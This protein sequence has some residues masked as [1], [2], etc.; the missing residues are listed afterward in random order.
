MK[1]Q[2]TKIRLLEKRVAALEKQIQSQPLEIISA[3]Y[4]IKNEQMKKAILPRHQKK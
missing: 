1:K 2:A 4:G 3:I